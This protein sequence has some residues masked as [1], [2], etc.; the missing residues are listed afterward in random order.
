[1]PVLRLAVLGASSVT[2]PAPGRAL[3]HQFDRR[4][5]TR[6]TIQDMREHPSGEGTVTTNRRAGLIGANAT[7]QQGHGGQQTR[8][9]DKTLPHA[10]YLPGK[11]TC[12]PERVAYALRAIPLVRQAMRMAARVAPGALALNPAGPAGIRQHA[13]TRT[14]D[15]RIPGLCASAT[16]PGEENTGRLALPHAD[17]AMDY[18]RRT[19]ARLERLPYPRIRR[20]YL[21]GRCAGYAGRQS[22]RWISPAR[23]HVARR[24]SL[25]RGRPHGELWVG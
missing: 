9:F 13:V 7:L 14:T 24:R 5:Q 17:P 3:L 1:M 16:L 25:R 11:E 21:L 6:P 10:F 15:V 12:R 20:T 4:L 19:Q 18:P 22:Y 2:T 8:A 23:S